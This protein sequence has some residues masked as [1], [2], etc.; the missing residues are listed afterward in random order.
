MNIFWGLVLILGGGLFLA[1]SLGYVVSMSPVFWMVVFAGMSVLFLVSYFLN[2]VRHW[3]W[4]FPALIF[5]STALTIGLSEAGVEGNLVAAPILLGVAVPFLV[6]FA[7]DPHK[8]WWALI[9]AW[10]MVVNT[11]LVLF[12][13]QVQG[14]LI[15]SMVLFSIALP[16]LVVYLLNRSKRWA[17]IPASILAVVGLFPMLSTRLTGTIMGAAVLLLMALPFLVAFV[18]TRKNWWTLIPAG[19]LASIGVGLL[20]LG[21]GPKVEQRSNLSSG[22]IFFGWAATFGVLWLMRRSSPTAWAK[23]PAVIMAAIGLIVLTLS[24]NTQ[25]LW[26][27]LLVGAGLV[28]L[29]VNLLPRQAQ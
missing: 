16:F 2:G 10:I 6:A 21:S 19:V 15:G 7:F 27:I 4:L 18:W 29:V 5:G 23:R 8:R 9:P 13:D 25:I 28:V 3:G 17:L 20:F 1:Q 11:S 14:E 22:L 12:S 26:P 24:A